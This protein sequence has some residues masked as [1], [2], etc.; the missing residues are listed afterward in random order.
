MHLYQS[1]ED[2][3]VDW[4]PIIDFQLAKS[5]ILYLY[6]HRTNAPG[7][8]QLNIVPIALATFYNSYH[9]TLQLLL[10]VIYNS[11]AQS[12]YGF[13]TRENTNKSMQSTPIHA[14][15]AMYNTPF[16]HLMVKHVE[17]KQRRLGE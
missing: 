15:P 13:F 2:N 16:S 7:I 5:H 10:V 8:T 11:L 9:Y 14:T 4:V 1:Q 12:I 17:G 6:L 3:L